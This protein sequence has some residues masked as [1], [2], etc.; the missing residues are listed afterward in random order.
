L[1]SLDIITDYLGKVFNLLSRQAEA[2]PHIVLKY[3]LV[4]LLFSLP[5]QKQGGMIWLPENIMQGPADEMSECH[6][7]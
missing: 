3:S 6:K 2:R 1:F 4:L 5:W 7:C